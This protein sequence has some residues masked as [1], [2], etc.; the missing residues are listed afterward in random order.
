MDRG[1]HHLE[2]AADEETGGAHAGEL[3]G[4][5]ALAAVTVEKTH[6]RN[7]TRG[8]GRARNAEVRMASSNCCVPSELLRC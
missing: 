7:P 2:R 4:V 6:A 1:G 8:F 5:L 3:L